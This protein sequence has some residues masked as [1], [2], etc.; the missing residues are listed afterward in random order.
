[1][2]SSPLLP[3]TETNSTLFPSPSTG[4]VNGI[5]YN[6]DSTVEGD[7]RSSSLSEIG[8]RV[9]NDDLVSTR[10]GV[11]G[12]SEANDTEAETERLED[13]PQK[14]LKHND[15]VMVSSS[16][17]L[18]NGTSPLTVRD[19]P[20]NDANGELVGDRIDQLSEITSL[21][22]S[23]EE[24]EKAAT[25]LSSSSRKRKR[26]SLDSLNPGELENK[27][28]SEIPPTPEEPLGHPIT[29][30]NESPENCV[31]DDH[32]KSRS[33]SRIPPANDRD[34]LSAQHPLSVKQKGKKGKR[35]VKK[36]RDDAP[37]TLNASGPEADTPFDI[38]A[39]AEGDYSNGDDAEMEDAGEDG[40]VDHIAR[41]EEG[42]LKKKCAMD[43]LSAIERCFASLRDK[44]FD[45]KLAQYNE[46]LVMLDQPN[47]THPEFVAMMRVIDRRRDE[48]IEY[49]ETLLRYKLI[50]LQKKSIAEKAQIH[51]QYMQTAREIR[52]RTLEKLHK[53]SYQLQRERRNAEG[54]VSD[55][56]YNF[57][58]KRS[59]QIT[60]QTAYNTEV[61]ILSGIAKHVGFPAAPPLSAL[62]SSEIEEDLQSMGITAPSASNVQS[63]PVPVRTNLS[64]L[65]TYPRQKPAAE[66][67]FL[68]QN[69]WANAQHPAHHQNNPFQRQASGL[70]RPGTPVA[71]PAAQRRIVDRAGPQG[72]ASTI[73]EPHSGPPSS[74]VVT[75]ATGEKLARTIED[76]LE[77][78]SD[79]LAALTQC[80]NLGISTNGAVST[81][82]AQGTLPSEKSRASTLGALIRSRTSS[83]SRSRVPKTQA[84]PEGPAKSATTVNASASSR[85]ASVPPSTPVRYIIKAEESL[86]PPRQPA[87]LQYHRPAVQASGPSNGHVDR[88]GA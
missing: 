84:V 82:T 73:A 72:S 56:A 49:E 65:A 60:N 22:D 6:R 8:D 87:S 67:Q 39:T 50:T 43:S 25:S 58:T 74:V 19:L 45:E 59:Q 76:G 15:V 9:G 62:R 26:S 81:P 36:T 27:P 7:D 23:G 37:T 64:T 75:P 12:G 3:P 20:P 68:E 10:L 28:G 77:V 2:T 41:N 40:E 29:T 5:Q 17:A 66:E 86:H 57:P 85:T 42:I 78:A 44:I 48:K 1:M 16:H 11:A 51:T 18:S 33:G 21:A 88:I 61:S 71:T 52:E 47:P 14:I 13:S 24:N 31:V 83:G 46:E 53:E 79:N 69:P 63:H 34:A 35:K 55:Y 4:L 80:K 30:H 70:S 32:Q 38:A 54:D